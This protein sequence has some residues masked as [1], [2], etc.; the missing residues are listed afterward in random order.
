MAFDICIK[1][2]T[3]PGEYATEGHADE[4]EVLSWHWGLTQSSSAHHGKGGGAGS[5]NVHDL[6]IKKYVDKASPTLVEQCFHGINQTEAI[7]CVRKAGDTSGMDF[8]KITMSGVV[9]ITSVQTGEAL[10]ND[11]YGETVTLNF[12]DVKFEYK[13]QQDDHSDGP[14]TTGS[15]SIKK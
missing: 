7:L 13:V 12:S 8:I 5:A 2:G 9:Y 10:P 6:T 1:I 11:M 14:V 15:F 4:I 3:I